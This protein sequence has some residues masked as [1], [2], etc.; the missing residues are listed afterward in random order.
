[1]QHFQLYKHVWSL[2]QLGR[3]LMWRPHTF[4]NVNLKTKFGGHQAK[5]KDFPPWHASNFGE[6]GFKAGSL[7]IGQNGLFS[8]PIQDGGF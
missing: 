7:L 4:K 8:T 6:L 5:V 2:D 3:C 1:M